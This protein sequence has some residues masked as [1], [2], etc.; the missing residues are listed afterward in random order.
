MV[1]SLDHD[2]WRT[3]GFAGRSI[4]GTLDI[5]VASEKT[6]TPIDPRFL[7]MRPSSR[8]AACMMS[9]NIG[10]CE[11]MLVTIWVETSTASV[12][13]GSDHSLEFLQRIVL[14]QYHDKHGS[15]SEFSL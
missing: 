13:F 2:C 15:D 9:L 3:K 7:Q 11:E 5:L 14:A 4:T 10:E 8:I 1:A 6:K 12:G